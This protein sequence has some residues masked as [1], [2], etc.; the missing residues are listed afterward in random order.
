[1]LVSF[2]GGRPN[3]GFGSVWSYRVREGRLSGGPGP[4][5][6]PLAMEQR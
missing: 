5:D 2:G 6:F 4:G 3:R 1:M